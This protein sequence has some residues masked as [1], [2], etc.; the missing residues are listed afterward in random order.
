MFTKFN[1]F[2]YSLCAAL[3]LSLSA[4]LWYY[5]SKAD[6]L[7]ATNAVL[8][9]TIDQEKVKNKQII[10]TIDKTREQIAALSADLSTV[11]DNVALIDTTTKQQVLELQG[12]KDRFKPFLAKP[13][14]TEKL[15][16]KDFTRSIHESQCLSGDKSKCV[17]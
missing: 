5:S 17:N 1:L 14:L 12:M 4:G 10:E 2:I 7:T 11:R 15:V 8:V 3:L 16:N 6:S 9:Q 13:G